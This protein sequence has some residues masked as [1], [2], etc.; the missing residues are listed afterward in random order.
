MESD[1]VY[2]SRRARE[3]RMAAFNAPQDKVRDRHIEMA[4]AYELRSRFLLADPPAETSIE[5]LLIIR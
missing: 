4:L 5:P 1:A 3:E 2:Y